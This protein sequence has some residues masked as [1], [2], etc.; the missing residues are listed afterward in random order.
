MYFSR[1]R[2]DMKVEEFINLRQGNM[3]KEEY[4]L[5]FTLFSM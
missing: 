5:M 4:S 2:R 3:S 1:D